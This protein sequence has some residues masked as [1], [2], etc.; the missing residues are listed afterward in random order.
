[1]GVSGPGRKGVLSMV[2]SHL[3]HWAA[4]AALAEL[5]FVGWKIIICLY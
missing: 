5:E 3:V 1:M 2:G 4:G